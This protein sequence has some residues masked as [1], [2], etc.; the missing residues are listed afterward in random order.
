[1]FLVFTFTNE[2]RFF[3]KNIDFCKNCTFLNKKFHFFVE[4][5]L[6]KC[7]FYNFKRKKF[8]QKF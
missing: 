7:L 8:V 5:S 1:M 2:M 3:F 6:Q 4:N